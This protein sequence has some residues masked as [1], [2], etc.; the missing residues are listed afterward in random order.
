MVRK[1]VLDCIESHIFTFPII[2]QD[3]LGGNSRTVMI[4][5]IIVFNS[6]HN[7]F[8]FMLLGCMHTKFDHD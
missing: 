8:E 7:L 4:G 1:I 5:E 3:S 2:L 6:L